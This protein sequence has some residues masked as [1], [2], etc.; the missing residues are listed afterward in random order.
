MKLEE[1]ILRI[2]GKQTSNTVDPGGNLDSNL[3]R[4]HSS[5]QVQEGPHGRGS[6]CL[7]FLGK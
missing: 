7:G 1:A 5:I 3:Q 6:L 4:I 2:E